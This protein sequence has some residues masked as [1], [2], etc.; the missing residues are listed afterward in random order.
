MPGFV[1]QAQLELKL[2]NSPVYQGQKQQQIKRFK[3]IINW[4]N[5]VQLN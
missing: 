4:E 5:N 2:N 3:Q 1:I